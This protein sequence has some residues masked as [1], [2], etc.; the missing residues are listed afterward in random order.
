MATSGANSDRNPLAFR[1]HVR[2]E[3]QGLRQIPGPNGQYPL[4][5][6]YYSRGFGVG[7]RHRGAAAVMQVTASTTYTPPSL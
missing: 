6:S 7:V 3:Y 2:R 4:A 5:E 1:Q